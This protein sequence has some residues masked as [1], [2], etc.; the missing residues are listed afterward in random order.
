MITRL[1]IAGLRSA[2]GSLLLRRVIDDDIGC[3]VHGSISQVCFHL[4]FIKLLAI[5]TLLDQTIGVGFILMQ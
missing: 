4:I 2:L 5:F 1:V 3:V